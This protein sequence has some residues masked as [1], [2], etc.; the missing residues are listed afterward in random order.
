[1]LAVWIRGE[2][3]IVR[4]LTEA[5][6]AAVDRDE[7]LRQGPH[8]RDEAITDY[9]AQKATL[10]ANGP[11]INRPTASYLAGLPTDPDRLLEALRPA[12][13]AAE[14]ETGPPRQPHQVID[15]GVFAWIHNLF[16]TADV[17]IPP[18]LKAALYRVLVKLSGVERVP[19]E[20]TIGGRTGIAIGLR[21]TNIKWGT[22]IILD[23]TTFAFVGTR[24]RPGLPEEST[25]VVTASAVV[26]AVGDTT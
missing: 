20:V 1:M 22:D 15:A 10:A 25:R 14:S 16:M 2:D 26:D 8:K 19:G 6:R 24:T 12:I 4:P 7:Y 11:S 13:A 9:G 17:I 5:D 18:A 23:A 21:A 3:G